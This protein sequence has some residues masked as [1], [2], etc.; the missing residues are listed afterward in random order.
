MSSYILSV[1]AGTTGITFCLVD[2]K[3]FKLVHQL[4]LPFEQIYP[5]PGLV[6]HDLELIWKVFNLGVKKTIDEF[7]E[8]IKKK[9][10]ILCIGITNQRETI[11]AFNKRGVPL[12][13]AI[14]WQDKRT[15]DYCEKIKINKS[16]E[17]IQ[18]KT[19]LTL[20]P[21]FSAT[22]INWLLN[23]NDK[24]KKAFKEKDLLF[25]TVDTYLLYRLTEGNSYATEA[26]N[27]SRTLLMNINNAQWDLELLDVF[28]VSK[29]ILP[30]IQE[31]FGHFGV[32]KGQSYLSDGIPITGILGDQQSALLGQNCTQAGDLKCTYGTGAFILINCGKE[33]GQSASGSL[34]TVFY[35]YKNKIHY[36]LEGSSFIAGAAVGWLRDNLNIISDAK[37][38]EA[39][40][41][42]VSNLEEMK[43]IL[44]LPFFSGIGSP[45]WIPKAQ[46]AILGMTRDTRK[47]H[48]ARAALEGIAL[49]IF[50]VIRNLEKNISN[51]QSIKVD[52]GASQNNLLLDIQATILQRPIVRP[53]IIE[54]T[55]YGAALAAAIGQNMLSIQDIGRY[56]SV[57]QTFNPKK[58]WF[59][60]YYQKK[61]QWNESIKRLYLN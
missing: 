39:L 51:I 11:C 46:A 55:V 8:I 7:Q 22:K 47:K 59:N 61:S 49:S 32:T 19:G 16:E 10:E 31:S 25:G 44:F 54:T 26:S 48:L 9:I 60:Y 29:E 23:N 24:V 37:E 30:P 33:K 5:A 18:H 57:D 28:E 35:K 53:K 14:V 36:A 6:E 13:N 21:Y 40:A 52:G 43:N 58:D 1:D 4:N 12:A 56:W 27:A 41:L 38:V 34:Q 3:S 42:K 17:W 2:P 20:D 50:D 45:Y 15:I